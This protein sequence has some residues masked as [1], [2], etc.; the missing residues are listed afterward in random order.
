MTPFIVFHYILFL[1]V[2]DEKARR[3]VV[4]RFFFFFAHLTT[5][6]FFPIVLFVVDFLFVCLNFLY[7]FLF[8]VIRL[9][10]SLP[11]CVY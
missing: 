5:L 3:K 7:R 4:W 8:P 10:P 9:S 6:S 2:M 1:S 11:S